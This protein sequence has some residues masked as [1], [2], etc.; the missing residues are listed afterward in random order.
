MVSLSIEETEEVSALNGRARSTYSS[1]FLQLPS[2][3][4]VLTTVKGIEPPNPHPALQCFR[5]LAIGW[6]Y[7]VLVDGLDQKT[8]RRA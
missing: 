4:E 5:S 3:W 7:T 6:L 8:R 2:T 1:S